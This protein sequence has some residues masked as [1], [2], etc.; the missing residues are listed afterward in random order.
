MSSNGK[1]RPQR[2]SR[3][4]NYD[5]LVLHGLWGACVWE[6]VSVSV[7]PMHTETKMSSFWWNFHHWLHWKLSFWQL[8]VQPV[9]NISS[10]WR[11]FR[12]SVN[13]WTLHMDYSGYGVSQWETTSQCSV[14]S[15]WLTL[16]LERSML[17]F[18][19]YKRSNFI[20]FFVKNVKNAE[21]TYLVIMRL[22]DCV[23]HEW[24]HGIS[25][26]NVHHGCGFAGIHPSHKS[27]TS[28]I[29]HNAPF[30]NRNGALWDIYLM[31]CG[32][33]DMGLLIGRLRVRQSDGRV[34]IMHGFI[35][36]HVLTDAHKSDTWIMELSIWTS[37]SKWILDKENK[38]DIKNNA[39]VIVNNDFW[40]TSEAICQWFSRVT[41]SRVKI[42]GKSYHEWPK[43]RYSR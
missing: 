40:V 1:T 28:S 11:L 43:N 9:M 35:I 38:C 39:W 16:Y 32:I 8:P 33:Y 22:F 7:W 30:C 24:P 26:Y 42:I 21:V 4:T 14:V 15:Y 23:P 2:V 6:S 13:G 3:A 34:D 27:H 37:F 25:I 19:N 10:K 18:I 20:H 17:Y 12:F 5:E 31:H 36:R 41:K 29:N